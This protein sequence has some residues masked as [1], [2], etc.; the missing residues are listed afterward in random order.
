[1]RTRTVVA[2]LA[3]LATALAGPARAEAPDT[4]YDRPATPAAAPATPPPYSLPWQLRPIAPVRVLR[5]DNV[6]DLHASGQ[7]DVLIAN[8]AWS[9]HPRMYALARVGAVFNGP[10]TGAAGSAA[11]N[12]VL[13]GAYL[14]PAIA[15]WRLSAFVGFSVPTATGGGDAPA[16]G[17][18]AAIASGVLPRS[19]MDAALFTPNDVTVLGGLGAAWVKDGVTL[20]AEANLLQFARVRGE[21]AQADAAKTNFNGGVHLGYFLARNL[22]IGGELRWQR[23]LSTPAAVARDPSLRQN[24]SGALGL[25]LHVPVGRLTLRPGFAYAA[26]LWGPMAT[27]G[28]HVF[29]VDVPVAFP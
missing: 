29:Q 22:S 8:A 27:G 4:A 18:R 26:G 21:Q 28:H 2:V 10:L 15:D 12:L 24:L 11:T 13:G 3:V 14:H 6:V 19:A 20:Q 9:F 16:P 25:R 1:M 7:T 23:W 17:P 5:V